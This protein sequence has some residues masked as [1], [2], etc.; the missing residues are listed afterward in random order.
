MRAHLER[1]FYVVHKDGHRELDFGWLIL[2]LC[3]VVGLVA[4]VLSGFAVF[5]APPWAWSW[6]GAFTTMAFIAGATISRAR[7]IAKSDAPGQVAAG[8]G[9]ASS[10]YR[11][12]AEPNPKT[13]DERG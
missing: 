7:L 9:S 5:V 2:A 1:L 8:I 13:D 3:C 10:G 6:F 4:F 12:E 11:A